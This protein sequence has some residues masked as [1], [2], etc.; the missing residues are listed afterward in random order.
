[1]KRLTYLAED[2]N[3]QVDNLIS[4]QKTQRSYRVGISDLLNVRVKALNQES[5]S[6]FHP[7]GNSEKS[8]ETPEEVIYF[9]RFL[10]DRH[11]EI[12]LKTH[13]S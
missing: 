8:M 5:A 7:I 9:D 2:K 10:E 11:G 6:M 12:R 3:N 13:T 4:F 1:M